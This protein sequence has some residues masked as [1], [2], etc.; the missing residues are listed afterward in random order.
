M[1]QL[2]TGRMINREH[3]QILQKYR[4][5]AEYYICACMNKNNKKSDN[6]IR[7]PGGLLYTRE[8]NNMQYVSSAA[9][10]LTVYSDH[11]RATNQVVN[12]H[13]G[14]VDPQEIL[15]F[16]KSQVDYILGSNPMGVSYLVGYGP[17]YPKRV[18]HRGASTV[19][20]RDCKAFVGCV[21][22][23]DT[24]F[25]YRDPNP[26]V[27]VGALVG[28]PG[29]EDEFM[30]RRDNF[31]QTE[32]CTYNTAPLVGLFAKFHTLENATFSSTTSP[33]LQR[34]QDL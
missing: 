4:S 12:C 26:N 10:L 14:R 19:S 7:T 21:Q 27:I 25:G 5:K 32:A 15:Y 22:G 11:L 16:A 31:A 3:K 28:G 1:T 13:A 33:S 30:D 8:W 9:L 20:Y 17:T 24:W 2:P 23:Y 6:V 29:V 18:H 34:F